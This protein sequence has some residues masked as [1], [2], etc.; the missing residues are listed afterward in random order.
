MDVEAVRREAVMRPVVVVVA[1]V[2]LLPFDDC[3]RATPTA[4]RLGA[5]V[6]DATLESR[7]EAAKA[8]EFL[9]VPTASN[10]ENG[11]SN[12]PL[13]LSTHNL[14]NH[15]RGT[16]FYPKKQERTANLGFL[17]DMCSGSLQVNSVPVWF[18]KVKIT[19]NIYIT[20]AVRSLTPQVDLG[21]QHSLP[22]HVNRQRE[23]AQ[24]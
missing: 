23:E 20:Q 3:V 10:A 13:F 7:R 1:V 19:I 5:D 12:E 8:I 6:L 16:S 18:L 17:H 11:S 2:W 21:T 9:M 15:P 24:N 22:N 4:V 14:I